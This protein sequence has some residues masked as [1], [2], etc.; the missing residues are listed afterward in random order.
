MSPSSGI[1]WCQQWHPATSPAWKS[2]C[3]TYA[4]DFQKTSRAAKAGTLSHSAEILSSKKTLCTLTLSKGR[5]HSLCFQVTSGGKRWTHSSPRRTFLRKAYSEFVQILTSHLWTM[6]YFTF[7]MQ[8]LS[9]LNDTISRGG[10]KHRKQS[11]F[12]ELPYEERL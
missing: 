12:N 5:G 4:P 9:F 7:H 8:H 1:S 3:R 2:L 11:Q 6:K 10:C